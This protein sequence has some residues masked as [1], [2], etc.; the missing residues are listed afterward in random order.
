MVNITGQSVSIVRL[1]FLFLLFLFCL[2]IS[3]NQFST[4]HSGRF[5]LVTDP[6]IFNGETMGTHWQVQLAQNQ[7]PPDDLQNL[8]QDKLDQLDHAIFSTWDSDS[9][10]SRINN[11]SSTEFVIS[12]D[13]AQ[14]LAVAANI[15]VTSQGGFD[16]RV[17]ELVNIW[18][19]GPEGDNEV[20]KAAVIDQALERLSESSYEVDLQSLSLVRSSG[21]LLDLSGIAKGFAVDELAEFLSALGLLHYLVEVGGEL[22]IQGYR[23]VPELAGFGETQN[24]PLPWRVALELPEVGVRQV[25]SVVS[26]MGD[27]A[28]AGS[29]DYRNFR[30]LPDGTRVSHEIDPRTGRPASHDLA[31]VTVF[32][33]KA[34]EADAWATAFMIM[35]PQESLRIAEELGLMVSLVVRKDQG[36]SIITSSALEQYLRRE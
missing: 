4:H 23:F 5:A 22:R 30:V 26:N 14:V 32:M 16:P 17:G 2:A 36:W 34:I 12:P 33:S 1:V 15:Q 8:I 10:L 13:L 21:L 11:S 18:G 20:P 31:G 29:G 28:I 25:A 35:G 9:E 19:F 7:N 6:Q 24:Q 27:I 3:W